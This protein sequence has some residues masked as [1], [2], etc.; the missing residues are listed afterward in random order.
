MELVSYLVS[1]ERC[2]FLITPHWEWRFIVIITLSSPRFAWNY[3]KPIWTHLWT[4]VARPLPKLCRPVFERALL[5]S[6]PQP[7]ASGTL[8]WR[9]WRDEETRL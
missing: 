6:L 1:M 7:D 5:L 8:T 4:N 2:C 9:T 3:V